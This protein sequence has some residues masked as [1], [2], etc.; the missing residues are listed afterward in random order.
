MSEQHLS[1]A[2]YI[3][4][5]IALAV[6]FVTDLHS[7][8]IKNFVTFPA[9]AL[10]LGLRGIF[11]GLG[12]VSNGTGLICGLFGLLTGGGIFYFIAR[13]YNAMGYGDVKLMAVVGA[14]VG[15]PAVFFCMA[16]IAFFGG[17]HAIISLIWKGELI[18]T[19]KRMGRRFARNRDAGDNRPG[20]TIP[21][22]LAITVGS[23]WGVMWQ[24]HLKSMDVAAGSFG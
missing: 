12:A 16:G 22:A 1:L 17:V 13:K 23:V 14:G 10:C 20:Q 21:Y 4:V 15:L 8:T 6:S 24:I 2:L 3:V 11:G 5:A 9:I 7:R 19:L 18:Y